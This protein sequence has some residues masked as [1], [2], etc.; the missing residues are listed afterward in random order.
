MSLQIPLAVVPSQTAAVVLSGQNC[1]I[2]LRLLGDSLY[3]SLSVDNV[4]LLVNHVA[5]NR[6]R[7]LL[8]QG[9]ERF[10][11]DFVF[12][13]TQGDTDP[14]YAGLDSRYFLLYLAEGELDV[15]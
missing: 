7:M 13:D 6:T 15:G 5:R 2:E 12:V 4:P 9:Y 8:A 3:F 11:G 1:Q 14:E 10:S